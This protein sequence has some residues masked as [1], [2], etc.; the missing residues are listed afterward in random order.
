MSRHCRRSSGRFD[1][2]ILCASNQ[3]S[4]EFG[5]S[6]G[7]QFNVVLNGGNISR[8]NLRVFPEPQVECG[9]SKEKRQAAPGVPSKARYDQSFVGGSFG[10]PIKNKL[11]FGVGTTTRLDNRVRP[12]HQAR[13]NR[14]GY[15]MLDS[16]PGLS[17]TNLGI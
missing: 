2:R 6:S 15:S 1:Q 16:I 8:R 4:A 14:G 5:H 9:R 7:G 12:Q 11:S 3:F 17:A 13:Y 10:G